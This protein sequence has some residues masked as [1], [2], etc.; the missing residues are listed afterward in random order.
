MSEKLGPITLRER[1]ELRQPVLLA[2]FA[3][4]P[5]AGEVATGALRFLAAK[6][7]T[8]ILGTLDLEGF[9]D[10][11][12]TRPLTIIEKGT[13]QALRYPRGDLSYWRNP[14][15]GRDVL[16]LLS[17]EPQLQWRRF[18]RALLRLMDA[19][20]SRL[21][22]NLGGLYDAVPHTSAPRISGLA[23]TPELRARLQEL[24]VALTEYQGPSSIHTSLVQACAERGF[25]GVSIWGHAPAY[26]RTVANP[27]VCHALLSRLCAL[28]ELPLNLDD[29]R[30]A[31][32][33]LDRTLDR[34]LG[35]NE[36]LRH[37]V[38]RLEEQSTSG[39]AA[40][41]GDGETERIIRDVEAFLRGEQRHPEEGN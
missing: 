19:F 18:T 16:L 34:L 5:D 38:R 21:L 28:L 26:V 11:T 3:G 37:Y 41:A 29:L 14:A 24:D 20:D 30:A 17:A 1:P 13:L 27:K 35:Q 40:G 33:Y 15:G 6:L 31:G 9:A 12:S 10:F 39:E 8:S 22:V 23:T 4:W 7:G 32:D 36:A 2:A 25:E